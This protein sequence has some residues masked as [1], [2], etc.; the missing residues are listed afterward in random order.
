MF[1]VQHKNCAGNI[2]IMEVTMKKWIS[3]V[4]MSALLI[5]ALPA[6]PVT[7]AEADCTGKLVASGSNINVSLSFPFAATEK[8]TSLRFRL[9]VSI[10]S[11]KI[12]K[13]VFQF[14]NVVKSEVKDSDIIN[15]NKNYI[16]DIIMSGKKGNLVFPSGSQADIGTL[17]LNPS[18]STYKIS[19]QFTGINDE[20]PSAEYVT[21]DGQSAIEVPLVNTEI[22]TVEKTSSGQSSSYSVSVPSVT[23]KPDPS[24]SPSVAPSGTPQATNT[25]DVNEPSVTGTPGTSEEPGESNTFD[26]DNKPN[27]SVSAKKG[28]RVVTFKWNVIDGADG[29]IIYSASG[30]SGNYKKI[31]NILKPER[32]SCN[33]TMAYASSYSFRMC[34]FKT[35]EDGSRITG[36]YSK[37]KKLTT[38]PAKVKGVKAKISGTNINLSWKKVKNSKGYQIYASKKKNGSYTLV[39]TLKKG[40][41]LKTTV[42]K[43]PKYK[44]FKVRAYVYNASKKR[45]YGNFCTGV[46]TR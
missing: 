28:S 18:G 33:V 46:K 45:V 12:D 13:P 41:V 6:Y 24:A 22:L 25:P 40:S 34:A 19:T 23:K 42:K 36:Q 5:T 26:K 14:N 44:Y 43:K 30:K 17:S 10:T 35:A 39:K 2:I 27:M 16:V 3:C 29:Y 4:L 15:D 1:P 32:T 20:T 38:A 31:R 37:V 7:A 8:I 21:E 11:G 9:K